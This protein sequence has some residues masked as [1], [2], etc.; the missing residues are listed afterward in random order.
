MGGIKGGRRKNMLFG[1]A[2]G[3]H[4][5]FQEHSPGGATAWSLLLILLHR[6]VD[7]ICDRGID[8]LVY[9]AVYLGTDS[10]NRLMQTDVAQKFIERSV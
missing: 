2:C 5:L 3:I 4:S 8:P 7:F 10:A 9:T 1:G 6:F